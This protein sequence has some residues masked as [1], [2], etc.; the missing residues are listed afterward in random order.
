MR[1]F[2]LLGVHS[3]WR[4][5]RDTSN[6][7]AALF[8]MRERAA[9]VGKGPGSLLGEAGLKNGCAEVAVRGHPSKDLEWLQVAERW[10]RWRSMLMLR[11]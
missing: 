8:L 1:Q 4:L 11:I 5:D 9:A 3:S 10:G 7:I 6:H 2:H